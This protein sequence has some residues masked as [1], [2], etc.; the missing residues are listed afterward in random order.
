M[1]LTKIKQRRAGKPKVRTGFG[2]QNCVYIVPPARKPQPIPVRPIRPI[3]PCPTDEAP[4][5]PR[6]P[7]IH[8]HSLSASVPGDE[9]ERY[10]FKLFEDGL[11]SDFGGYF[12][13]PF[14][15]HL[16]P[17]QC[18]HEP[19]I[20]H[21]ILALSAIHSF[22]ASRIV[23][24]PTS[25][26]HL[27]FA[28]IQQNKAIASLQNHMSSEHP[29]IRLVLIASLLFAWVESFHNNL[30]TAAKQICSGLAILKWWQKEGRRKRKTKED[31]ASID[32][33]LRNAFSRF[34]LQLRSYLAMN[35]LFHDPRLDDGG[36][37]VQDI[38]NQFAT[39]DE[40]YLYAVKLFKAFL[41]YLRRSPRYMDGDI[42]LDSCEE[43]RK[44]MEIQINQWKKAYLRISRIIEA[45]RDID[46][47]T[48]LAS[49]QLMA[50]LLTFEIMFLTSMTKDEC[51]FDDF[52][53]QFA[54][55]VT[56][57]RFLREKDREIRMWV[58]M[59][60]FLRAQF[61]MGI[62]M[63][64]YF[65]ATRCRESSVR[66]DAVAILKE[67]PCRN[68]MWDS[69]QAA[70]VAEWVIEREE[71]TGGKKFIPGGCRVRA[72]TLKMCL[73]KDGIQVECMQGPA[74]SSQKLVRETLV[75]EQ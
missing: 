16:I 24:K 30:D 43:E 72:S 49:I 3:R 42:D 39:L 33:D 19:T 45:S 10:Y 13:T 75:W 69:L 20:R 35:P 2:E 1:Q 32:P 9:A 34:E 53:Q 31:L 71:G 23:G 21:A 62:I 64:L 51:Q 47:R 37:E 22:R 29:Q 17:Q 67:F 50:S 68:G 8:L 18:H 12:E 36:E 55:I 56:W 59:G 38:P 7:T 73:L 65:T 54:Q 63:S 46:T 27:K 57:C 60:A 41:R 6:V 44:Y 48:H 40:A 11:S 5:R 52:T 4:L 28:L 25:G 66:R 74:D 15:T 26:E 61:G 58:G 70:R 14:W